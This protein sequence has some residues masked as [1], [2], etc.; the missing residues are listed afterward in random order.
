MY[1]SGSVRQLGRIHRDGRLEVRRGLLQC[2]PHDGAPEEPGA[3]PLQPC[4]GRIAR[5]RGKTMAVTALARKLRTTVYGVVKSGQPYD[6][7][8]VQPA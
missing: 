1:Q 7:R 3:K 4:D 6:P 2:A 5:R 8:K